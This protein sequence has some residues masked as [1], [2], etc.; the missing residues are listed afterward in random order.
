[1]Q[2]FLMKPNMRSLLYPTSTES[3]RYSSYSIILKGNL[4]MIT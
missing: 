3:T 4:Q 1:M 2:T